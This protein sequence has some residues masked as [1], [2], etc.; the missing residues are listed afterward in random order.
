MQDQDAPPVEEGETGGGVVAV[1]AAETRQAEAV[2]AVT[3][4]MA[5]FTPLLWITATGRLWQAAT[6]DQDRGDN[7]QVLPP[8]TLRPSRS[9]CRHARTQ[10]RE[11]SASL[12]ICSSRRRFRR[13][14]AS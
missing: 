10:P 9:R 7:A 3:S 2:P 6:T 12:T 5:A 4:S 8:T 14:R 1:R 11:S 13:R